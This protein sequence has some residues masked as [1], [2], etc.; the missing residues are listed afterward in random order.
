MELDTRFMRR[1]PA[2]IKY[3]ASLR[4]YS[5]CKR[6]E[7]L[8]QEAWRKSKICQWME[9]RRALRQVKRQLTAAT[10]WNSWDEVEG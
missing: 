7:H 2:L 6:V 5:V 10:Q 9:Q 1:D 4:I 8:L 3:P